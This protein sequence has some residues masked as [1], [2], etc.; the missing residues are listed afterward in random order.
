MSDERI[1]ITAQDVSSPKV[2]EVL[3]E[4]VSFGMGPQSPPPAEDVRTG[5]LY[6][7]WFSIMVAGALGGLFG[8]AAAE[9][10][11][12]DGLYFKGNVVSV[13][14][15]DAELY[16]NPGATVEVS[17]TM[18]YVADAHTRIEIDGRATNAQSLTVGQVVSVRG[19]VYD[20][21]AEPLFI[22]EEIE[23]LSKDDRTYAPVS[24]ASLQIRETLFGLAIFPIIAAFV[25]LFVG[26]ADGVVSRSHYRALRCGVLGMAVGLG[27]SVIVAPFGA[28]IYGLGT[29]LVARV[30]TSE[31]GI[32]TGAFLVQMMVRGL[33]WCVIGLGMGLGQGV[34]MRSQRLLVNG[35]I[36]GSVGSLM[37]GLLFDPIDYLVKGGDMFAVGGAEASRAIG[38]LVIGGCTGLMI[39]V[40]ELLARDAWV[41]LLTGP[42]AGKEFALYRNPTTVGSSPK[43][44]IY[45]F[46]DSE[47]EPSH[48]LLHQVGEH[49]EIEDQ[50]AGAGTQVNGIGVRRRTL[51]DGDQIKIGKTVVRFAIKET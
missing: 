16:D 17:G 50:G 23:V 10:F 32:S 12:E 33:A 5:L 41:K 21:E 9:P 2:D 4:Q 30:N 22:A 15:H 1:V 40:V 14:V 44:D 27:L 38:F 45:L 43:S 20:D 13:T 7:P 48:A 25:G 24:L 26:A 49:W 47:V 36:G 29:G 42:L 46:K 28:I 19:D 6:R 3:A 37:G 11:F 35:V 34:A 31:L 8:W 51:V 18:V 39:G